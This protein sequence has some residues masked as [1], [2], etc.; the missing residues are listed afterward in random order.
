M[1][2]LRSLEDKEPVTERNAAVTKKN[3][4]KL[5]PEIFNMLK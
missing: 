4:L 5:P 3:G 2:V 1:T